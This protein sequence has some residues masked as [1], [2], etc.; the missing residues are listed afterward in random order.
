MD[1]GIMNDNNLVPK[2]VLTLVIWVLLLILILSSCTP[3]AIPNKDQY[4]RYGKGVEKRILNHRK[5]QAEQKLRGYG[6]IKLN[7]INRLSK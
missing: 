3:Y 5:L 6:E 7:R 1:A 2:V 4:P